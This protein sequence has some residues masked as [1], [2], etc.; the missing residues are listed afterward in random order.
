MLFIVGIPM[1]KAQEVTTWNS[2]LNP[3]TKDA[4]VASAG[5]GAYYAFRMP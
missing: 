2:S 1:L 5:S 3:V 4:L